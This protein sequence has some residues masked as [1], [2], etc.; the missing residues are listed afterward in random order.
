ME[1][2]DKDSLQSVQN[3]EYPGKHDSVLWDNK[4]SKHPGK[5]K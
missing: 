2:E 3:G 1:D 4:Q 5:S